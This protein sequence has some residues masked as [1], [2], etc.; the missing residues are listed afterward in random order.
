MAACGGHVL[1]E[2]GEVGVLEAVLLAPLLN[3]WLQLVVVHVRDA[4]EQMVLN[5]RDIQAATAMSVVCIT[6]CACQQPS[7]DVQARRGRLLWKRT[8]GATHGM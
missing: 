3:H 8:R 7:S 5:L 4:R 2:G 6:D 1:D